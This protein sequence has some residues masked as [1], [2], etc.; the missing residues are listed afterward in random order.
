MSGLFAKD[1]IYHY[2]AGKDR[3]AKITGINDDGTVK[4]FVYGEHDD[5]VFPF[6]SGV[7][8]FPR[9]SRGGEIGQWELFPP[10]DLVKPQKAWIAMTVEE[11]KAHQENK[12]KGL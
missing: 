6:Q 2:M 1:A 10:E 9:V 12:A 5:W 11:R 4:L 3:L 7:A 8:R